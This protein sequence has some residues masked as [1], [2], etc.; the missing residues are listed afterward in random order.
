MEL[1]STSSLALPKEIIFCKDISICCPSSY[2]LFRCCC[3]GTSSSTIFIVPTLE[4]LNEDDF[5]KL[6]GVHQLQIARHHQCDSTIDGAFCNLYFRVQKNSESK[7]FINANFVKSNLIT[8]TSLS[9]FVLERLYSMRQAM[10]SRTIVHARSRPASLPS[11]LAKILI[12]R[13]THL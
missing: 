2:S 8:L 7:C 11:R 13:G 3:T 1:K 5:N 12:V 9:S 6:D 4:M 10:M